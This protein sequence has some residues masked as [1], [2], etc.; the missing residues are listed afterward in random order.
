MSEAP[1]FR[2]LR[3]VAAFISAKALTNYF[4]RNEI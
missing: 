2:R 4:W 1:L 3:T